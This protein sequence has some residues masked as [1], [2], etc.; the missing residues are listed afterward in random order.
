[1]SGRGDE[2]RPAQR[3]SLGLAG[4]ERIDSVR[5]ALP[6][7]HLLDQ[8]EAGKAGLGADWDPVALKGTAAGRHGAVE[9]GQ[10]HR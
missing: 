8:A 4:R 7:S 9:Q 1:M 5:T 10:G 2:R 6:W 3:G